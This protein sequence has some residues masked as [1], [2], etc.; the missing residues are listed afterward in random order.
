MAANPRKQSMIAG[1]SVEEPVLKEPATPAPVVEQPFRPFSVFHEN[2]SE[3]SRGPTVSIS[4]HLRPGKVF[5]LFELQR[6][7]DIGSTGPV[8]LAEDLVRRQVD[9]VSLKFLPDF[10]VSDKTAVTE[11][12]NE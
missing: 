6:E 10:I 7:L 3:E 8:W 9:K 1:A 11:L 12:K 4:D 2:R 5:A